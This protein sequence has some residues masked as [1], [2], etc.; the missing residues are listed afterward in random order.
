MKASVNIKR[1][2]AVFTYPVMRETEPNPKGTVM[3]TKPI[4]EIIEWQSKENYE[5]RRAARA[6]VWRG[7]RK[8]VKWTVLTA[9]VISIVGAVM[10]CKTEKEEETV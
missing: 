3:K 4:N 7:V 8:T 2:S 9:G 1:F 6:R 10:N 5:I